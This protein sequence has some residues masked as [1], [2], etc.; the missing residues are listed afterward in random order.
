MMECGQRKE[1]ECGVKGKCRNKRRN[2]QTDRRM[3]PTC[4]RDHAGHT[5][6]FL[7]RAE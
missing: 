4:R 5:S 2:R 6:A 7:P 3:G 1:K